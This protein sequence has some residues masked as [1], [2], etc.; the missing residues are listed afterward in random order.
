M[1][2]HRK[3]AK[4]GRH[5]RPETAMSDLRR[6]LAVYAAAE[7]AFSAG[8]RG[9]LAKCWAHR[10]LMLVLPRFGLESIR[11]IHRRIEKRIGEFPRDELTAQFEGCARAYLYLMEKDGVFGS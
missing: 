5:A 4:R 3:D 2:H 7:I 6:R 1:R 8:L 10:V 9:A 11:Q